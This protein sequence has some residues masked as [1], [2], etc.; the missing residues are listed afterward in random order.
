M[1]YFECVFDATRWWY[2]RLVFLELS[3]VAFVFSVIKDF[4]FAFTNFVYPFSAIYITLHA[5]Y[6][7]NSDQRIIR[8][9]WPWLLRALDGLSYMHGY[10]V[11]EFP[12]CTSTWVYISMVV[13]TSFLAKF[14]ETPML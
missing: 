2:C 14:C 6:L 11:G 10:L 5:T 4:L 8:K 13:S 7:H 3:P 12:F 9:K 1:M